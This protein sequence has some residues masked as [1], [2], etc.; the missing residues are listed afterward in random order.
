[1]AGVA[2]FWVL[3]TLRVSKMGALQIFIFIEDLLLK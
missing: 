1:V 2:P 3:E